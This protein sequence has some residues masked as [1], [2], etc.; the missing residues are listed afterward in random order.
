MSTQTLRTGGHS[1][2]YS[3]IEIDAQASAAWDE[4]GETLKQ[5]LRFLVVGSTS[6]AVDFAVYRLILSGGLLPRD[7]AKAA[8]YLAGVV[9]GFFGNKWWTFESARRSAA[10]PVSYL[11]LYA[12]TLVVNVACNRAALALLGESGGTWAFLFATGVTTVLNFLGMKLVTFR[13]GIA[14]RRQAEGVRSR[15]LNAQ[16]P[17]PNE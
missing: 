17:I 9:V 10:E 7:I 6:V 4:R 16:V 14:D 15:M 11:A 12:A 2:P 5:V 13:R 3:A 1:P 8:S